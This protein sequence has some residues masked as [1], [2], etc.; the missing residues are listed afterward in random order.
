MDQL[1]EVTDRAHND[2]THADS[3]ADLD[4]LLS[5]G[6]GAAIEELGAVLDKVAR[7]LG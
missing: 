5:V 3:L 4:E 1:D 7:D 6:L 2:E